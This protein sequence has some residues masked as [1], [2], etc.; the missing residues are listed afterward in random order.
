MFPQWVLGIL[1]FIGCD[2]WCGDQSLPCKEWGRLFALCL[3]LPSLGQGLLCGCSSRS[4]QIRLSCCGRLVGLEPFHG[5][6]VGHTW[7]F[8]SRS[9][10]WQCALVSPGSHCAGSQTALLLA[11][12]GSRLNCGECRQSAQLCKVLGSQSHQCRSAEVTHLDP[13]PTSTTH[14]GKAG[15]H[16]VLGSL[17]TGANSDLLGCPAGAELTK[18]PQHVN[19]WISWLWGTLLTF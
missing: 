4:P 1:P 2:W 11:L 13:S 16:G 15:S 3:A 7:V 10:P 5:G 8:L 6:R 18:L 17:A 19:L 9:H 12:S 14:A